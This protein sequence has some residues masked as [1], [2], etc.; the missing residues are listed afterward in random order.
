[1]LF[2]TNF[3]QDQLLEKNYPLSQSAPSG[4]ETPPPLWGL[5]G[6]SGKEGEKDR[7]NLLKL[8]VKIESEPL[9]QYQLF[10][11]I[12]QLLQEDLRIRRERSHYHRR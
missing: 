9:L 5:Q 10:D 1:M 2:M 6:V 7:Q 4:Y 11:R 12:Y 3:D 8:A